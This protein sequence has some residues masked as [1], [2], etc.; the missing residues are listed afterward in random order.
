MTVSGFE[1]RNLLIHDVT[2]N[3][4]AIL[5][6][7]VACLQPRSDCF[8][9]VAVNGR[10]ARLRISKQQDGANGQVNQFMVLHE[11]CGS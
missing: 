8:G 6:V 2:N 11:A 10:L 3:S 7:R 4:A 1:V 5:V 9:P